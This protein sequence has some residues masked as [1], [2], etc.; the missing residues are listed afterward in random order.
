MGK[1]QRNRDSRSKA[2]KLLAICEIIQPGKGIV[3]TVYNG[4]DI[5]VSENIHIY[6]KTFLQTGEKMPIPGHK[7]VLD[8]L[9]VTAIYDTAADMHIVTVEGI[10][11]KARKKNDV[12]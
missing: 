9:E 10:V 6:C 3:W 5:V 7:L 11:E 12:S 4:K 8:V 1:G 2:E